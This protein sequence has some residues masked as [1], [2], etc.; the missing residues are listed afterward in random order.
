[1]KDLVSHWLRCCSLGIT[2]LMSQVAFTQTVAEKDLALLLDRNPNQA[3]RFQNQ[4]GIE[5]FSPTW[6]Q[7]L[8]NSYRSTPVGRAIE[9]ENRYHDWQLVAMRVAPCE[10]LGITPK[11]QIAEHC[12]P[13][14]RLIWQPFVLIGSQRS[15][16]ADDRAIHAIYDVFPDGALTGTEME[17]VITLRN[18]LYSY[19]HGS[20]N[21]D[22]LLNQV[23]DRE[24]QTLRNKVINRLLSNTLWLRTLV[25]E[26]HQLYRGHGIR[27]EQRSSSAG[28]FRNRLLHWLRAYTASNLIKEV[29]SFSL[30]AG[31]APGSINLW[32][33]IAFHQGSNGQLQPRPIDIV[34]AEDGHTLFNFGHHTTVTREQE[35]FRLFQT[36]LS[37]AARRELSQSV[38]FHTADRNRLLAKIADRN[39]THTLTT[40]CASCHRFNPDLN[41]MHNMSY[42]VGQPQISLAARVQRDVAWDLSWLARQGFIGTRVALEEFPMEF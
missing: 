40:S 2:L 10:P 1:M 14:V 7:Q 21:P 32:S 24:F 23:E 18:R 11:D 5:L 25:N 4:G 15:L 33:M 19:Y 27:P 28:E 8:L 42:F 36:N 9:Q 31:R 37:I 3:V 26:G 35:D 34:S 22:L 16:F 41:N 29:T 17:R 30:P 13:E 12:W 38:I 6:Y 20:R 39:Q